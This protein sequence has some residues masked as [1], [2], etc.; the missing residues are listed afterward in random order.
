V[1]T[2]DWIAIAALFLTFLTVVF[3]GGRLFERLNNIKDSI[4][5]IK[6]DVK[7]IPVISEKVNIL[8]ADKFTTSASPITLNE[9]GAKLLKDSGIEVLTDKYYKQIFDQIKEKN[10]QN[11]YQAQEMLIEV[12][13]DFKNITDCKN[14]LE[15]AAFKTGVDIDSI[16][17]VAAVNIRDKIVKELN[18]DI[19]D[20]DKFTPPKK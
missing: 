9:R 8:W 12:V 18:F 19:N 15:E 5:E 20:I 17:L 11:A 1:S 4:N 6:P 13:R 2:G 16:L 10:L 3:G 14:K 7:T